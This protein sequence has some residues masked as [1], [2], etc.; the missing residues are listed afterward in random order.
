LDGRFWWRGFLNSVSSEQN[1]EII[2]VLFNSVGVLFST[3]SVSGEN[4]EIISVLLLFQ[5]YDGDMIYSIRCAFVAVYNC[6]FN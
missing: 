3:N 6:L 1:K 4:K 5:A 2:S